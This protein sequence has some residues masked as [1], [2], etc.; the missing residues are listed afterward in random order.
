MLFRS[1]PVRVVDDD[2]DVGAVLDRELVARKAIAGQLR[3]EHTRGM[4]ADHR[5]RRAA[6]RLVNDVDG[7]GG[8]V[9]TVGTHNHAAIFDM[10][11]EQV[12]WVVVFAARFVVQQWL[13]AINQV[14]WLAFARIAQGWPLT[15]VGALITVW[16]V[17]KADL[18]QKALAEPVEEEAAEPA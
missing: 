2:G 18:R 6:A 8:R 7:H 12:V 13:Y 17:R 10:R 16:A 1:E 3:R 9:G 5:N 4:D 15:I 14:G 11:A